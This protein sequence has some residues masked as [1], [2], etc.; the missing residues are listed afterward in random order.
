MRRREAFS[1]QICLSNLV[2]NRPLSLKILRKKCFPSIEVPESLPMNCRFARSWTVLKG[3]HR[4]GS[5]QCTV[6]VL[7][8]SLH[9]ASI[10][11]CARSPSHSTVSYVVVGSICPSMVHKHKEAKAA[12]VSAGW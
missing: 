2:T 9:L 11:R 1:Q 12:A 5:I 6:A 3:L 4:P 7:L 10:E 8:E